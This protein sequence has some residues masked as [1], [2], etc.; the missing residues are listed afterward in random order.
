LKISCILVCVA[1]LSLS[2]LAEDPPSSRRSPQDLTELSL[3]ELL[4]VPVVT[5]N[6]V[7]R[8]NQL[9]T[10]APA[11]VS[12]VTGDEI[13]KFG[14]R[15]LADVLRSVPGL[16]VTYDRNY[17][18]LGIRGFNRSGDYN[19]RV[20][21][22]LDGHRLNENI[23]DSVLLGT[24]EMLDVENIE[25]IEVIRGPGS[26]I[27]GNNAFFGVLNIISK[28]G[29]QINGVEASAE[30]GSFE[31]FKGRLS[32]GKRFDND[33]EW[34]LSGSV[35]H[36]AGDRELYFKEFDNPATH[37][38]IAE[39][40]DGDTAYHAF[41]SVIYHDFTLTGLFSQREKN[42]PTASYDTL[43]NDGREETTDARAYVDLKYHKEI[44]PDSEFTGRA[45]YDYYGY[46]GV[47]PYDGAAPGDPPDPY[48]NKDDTIGQWTGT[49][50]HWTQKILDR[51]TLAAG[52]EF[53]QN[54]EQEQ[55]NYDDPP[56]VYYLRDDRSTLTF[57]LYGEMELVLATNLLINAELRYD[58][59][60]SFGDTVNPRT[61]LI[62][63]PWPKTTGKLIYSQAFRAPNAFESYYEAAGD[64]KAN[65]D[66]NPETIRTYEAVLEQDLPLKS[67]L[68][69]S[70]FYY[71]ID[72]L[73]SQT[74][75]P[76]DGLTVFENLDR[77]ETK[78]LEIDW[79]TRPRRGWMARTSYTF[80]QAE[81]VE[82]RKW[83]SNS[84]RHLA[85]VNLI[86]PLY[87]DKL[88][89]GFEVQYY[90]DMNTVTGNRVDDYWVANL[91]L[92]SQRILR[93]LECSASIYNL[94]DTRFDH[95]ATIDHIQ[96]VIPQDGIT[97]R[98]KLT[99][100]F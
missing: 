68:S 97:F 24:E 15:T 90:G 62:Y 25:R 27:Y 3:E 36:S 47:Y 63:N 86:A 13:E 42:I 60:E 84:P 33:L 35:Y 88:F 79:E 22:L 11:A 20:L 51:H 28:R 78:G 55:V 83:L 41:S 74:V 99:Y 5:V 34:L 73:I 81:N 72:D 65:P 48:L 1:A 80:Q 6:G 91:T 46:W 43:F 32:Y 58:Y 50:L 96:S 93:G 10:R 89:G 7:S 69:L 77:A 92:Y 85:K 66:L 87:E 100:R 59:Y 39:D 45:F 71:R 37:N 67:R 94:F 57:G 23:Y 31:T 29:S 9:V 19:S 52:L 38:G 44:T 26:S 64:T 95:P 61:A 82:T 14:Y 12:V 98:L 18:Y 2:A 70:A 76:N 56:V 4:E 30:G 16:Y 40:S 53:R 49:E 8:F 17:S 75:D 54:L 21:A